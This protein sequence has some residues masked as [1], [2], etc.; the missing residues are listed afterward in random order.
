[1][2]SPRNRTM[3]APLRSTH[4]APSS[5]VF[6]STLTKGTSPAQSQRTTPSF[7][8]LRVIVWT[9]SESDRQYVI[10]T[11]SRLGLEPHEE[12][13]TTRAT[14]YRIR[15]SDSSSVRRQ[16][17]DA[18][19]R[20]TLTQ[21]DSPN[22][23]FSWFSVA[24]PDA[25]QLKI[26]NVATEVVGEYPGD[27]PGADRP[28]VVDRVTSSGQGQRINPE[29]TLANSGVRDDDS[30]RVSSESYAGVSPFFIACVLLSMLTYW[31]FGNSPSL[32]R[33]SMSCTE[34]S[35]LR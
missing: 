2:C 1:M 16:L 8:A 17:E 15:A 32:L 30:L 5:D 28:T 35:H 21:P 19:L 25:R 3:T 24:D 29:G 6:E 4:G 23:L 20:W 12:W 10:E 9:E 14:S 22:Y 26:T 13:S 33:R 18:D 31:I 34:R 7:E 11:L 27:F